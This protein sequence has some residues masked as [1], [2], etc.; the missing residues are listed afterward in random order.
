[1]TYP[2]CGCQKYFFP[3]ES[4]S[5]ATF[6]LEF[7]PQ[8]NTF[9]AQSLK[10]V[11]FGMKFEVKYRKGERFSGEKVLPRTPPGSPVRR[12]VVP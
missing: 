11:V 10:I 1:M 7:Q 5:L 4:L 12:L 8:N 6:D 2:D 9:E 3:A